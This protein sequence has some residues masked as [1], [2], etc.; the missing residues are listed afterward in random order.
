MPMK[1]LVLFATIALQFLAVTYLKLLDHFSI[2]IILFL[3][4]LV[5]GG[6]LNFSKKEPAESGLRA[7]GWGLF[8]GSVASLLTVGAFMIFLLFSFPK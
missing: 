2:I 6:V 7:I 3:L 8:Y 5:F 4:C 1:Y